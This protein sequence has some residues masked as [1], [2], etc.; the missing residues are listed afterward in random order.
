MCK[1]LLKR[2]PMGYARFV[3]VK[4]SKGA[5]LLHLAAH[6]QKGSK[7][8]HISLN[9]S[10]LTCA[11]TGRYCFPGSTPLHLAAR[12]GF[13]DCIRELLAWGADRV[14]R[15]HSGFNRLRILGSLEVFLKQAKI[16][17]ILWRSSN[18]PF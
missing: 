6:Q 17:K 13:L 3:D 5:T 9:N 8:A 12:A 4:D 16:S 1:C 11:S 15:D 14:Q 2:G 10:A 7:C 18:L